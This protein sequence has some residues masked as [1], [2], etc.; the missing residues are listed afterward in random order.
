MG[1]IAEKIIQD[2]YGENPTND[3]QHT[4]VGFFNRPYIPEKM[5]SSRADVLTLANNYEEWEIPDDTIALY[6]GVDSQKDHFWV[7][8]VAYEYNMIS[9]LVH[10]SR[11]EDLKSI[12][13]LAERYYYYQNG[14]RYY[15]G[16]KRIAI[17]SRGYYEKETTFNEET[18]QTEDNI[19]VDIPL[20][21]REFVYEM[22]QM[23]GQDKDSHEKIYA[24][25]GHDFLPN[26]DYYGFANTNVTVG[27]YDDVRKIKTIKLGTV[28][29]KIAFLQT[30]HRNIA[31]QK[32]TESDEAYNYQHRLH[33][34]NKATIEHIKS[35]DK[36]NNKTYDA[37]I[38]AERYGYSANKKATE[39]KAFHKIRNDNHYLDC[40]VQATQFA[41][42]DNL[43][44]IKK[45]EEKKEKFSISRSIG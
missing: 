20:Q 2:T 42:M 15:Q 1:K 22:S 25:R 39:R 35:L 11:V 14:K 16:I 8:I 41:I 4:Y 19:V 30:V 18:G 7:T 34:V 21:V 12:V 40:M 31:R 13:D 26:D 45:P 28:Q 43:A 6:M 10:A 3:L 23:W 33:Y 17:D 9:H 27:K 37:Q 29:L 5:Q 32:A 36:P 44:S 24:T 38:T